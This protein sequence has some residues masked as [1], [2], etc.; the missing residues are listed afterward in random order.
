MVSY[1]PS[2]C[3]TTETDH[4]ARRPHHL[5]WSSVGSGWPRRGPVSFRQPRPRHRRSLQRHRSPGGRPLET[6][7]AIATEYRTIIAKFLPIVFWR[8]RAADGLLVNAI[9]ED[10]Q[11]IHFLLVAP[12]QVQ[13]YAGDTVKP[14]F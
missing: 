7:A 6:H 9:A 8:Q 13:G 2:G 4:A 14:L 12:E 3:S 5:H 10:W 11:R 1:S